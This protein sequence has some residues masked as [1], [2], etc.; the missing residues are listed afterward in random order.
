[1]SLH[2]RWHDDVPADLASVKR[3]FGTETFAEARS[4]IEDLPGDPLLGDWLERHEA[5]GDLSDCRKVKFGPD[6]LAEDGTSLGPA[7]RLIYRLLPSNHDP[8][9]VEVLAVAPRRDLVAYYLASQR[10]R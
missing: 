2:L 7:L 8:Q 5:T 10:I 4:L 3:S 9:T 1:V 6:E